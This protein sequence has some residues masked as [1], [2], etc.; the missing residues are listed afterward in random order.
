MSQGF[1]VKS[2]TRWQDT[3][4]S[5]LSASIGAVAGVAGVARFASAQNATPEATPIASPDGEGSGQHLLVADKTDS[6]IYIYSIPDFELT[7]QLDGITLGVHGGTLTLEDGRVIFADLANEEIVAL[8][9][10][11]DGTPEIVNRVAGTFGGGVAWVSADPDLTHVVLGSLIEE[12][13]SQFLNVVD[14]ATFENA[15]I[16]FEMLEPEEIHG[17]LLGD[18]LHL[19]IAIG[20][21]VNS[22]VLADILA[23]VTEPL[24]TVSAELGS[25]GGTSDARNGRIFYTTAPGTGFEV[26]DASAG[27]AEYLTQIPWDLDGLTGGRNAR[28]RTTTDATHILG[29]MTPGLDDP[30]VW[31]ETLVSIHITNVDDLTAV[32]LPIDTGSFGYRWGITDRYVLWAG[33][34]ASGGSAYLI[35]ADPASEGFGTVVSTWETPLP[36]NAAVAGEDFEGKETYFTAITPDSRLGF[37]A[38]N[39]DGVVKVYDLS[40]GSEVSEVGEIA[41]PSTQTGG[42]YLTVVQAGIVPGD[43]WG[44]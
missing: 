19:H 44:R 23:G 1:T 4:R 8:A 26:L 11:V 39:G 12:G 37:V 29:L 18:P 2:V 33:Y 5:V 32:R 3:R 27:P 36:S 43:L 9:I 20:G 15:A 28:P 7:G 25:H 38:V 40:K 31:A 13:T 24:S 16:E 21:Q 41:L 42:G 22:Y 17:W 6:V 14:L 30:T 10:S 34:N 35:D